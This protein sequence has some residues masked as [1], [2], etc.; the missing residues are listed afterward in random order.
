MHLTLDQAPAVTE[1]TDEI[2]QQVAD[3]IG[4]H[5]RAQPDYAPQVMHADWD[6]GGGRVIVWL[7]GL[8]DWAYL[9][10]DGGISEDLPDVYEPV[11]LPA[12][13][14]VEPVNPQAL[15]VLPTV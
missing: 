8:T 12:G 10:G 6:G 7:H 5:F 9:A 13:V 2:A 15:R 11:P 14:W 4:E 3:A 1:V